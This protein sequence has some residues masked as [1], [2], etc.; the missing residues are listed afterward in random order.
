MSKLRY[1]GIFSSCSYSYKVKRCGCGLKGFTCDGAT[2]SHI[3]YDSKARFWKVANNEAN[4]DDEVLET[5]LKNMKGFAATSHEL[6]T[7]IVD[8]LWRKY[9]SFISRN[10]K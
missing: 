8:P 6:N 4:K 5:L 2:S 1:Q 10:K 7:L 9:N 3:E